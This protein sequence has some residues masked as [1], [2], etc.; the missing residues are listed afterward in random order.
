MAALTVSPDL[1]SPDAIPS[2]AIPTDAMPPD[3]IQPDAVVAPLAE[4]PV[5]ARYAPTVRLHYSE[6]YYPT[7]VGFFIDH[8][9]LRFSLQDAG[10]IPIADL[11]HVEPRKLGYRSF[12]DTYWWLNWRAWDKTRPYE[13]GRDPGLNERD[14]FFS[15]R[16][17]RPASSAGCA[18]RGE[19]S[20]ARRSSGA[21]QP[22]DSSSA[23]IRR[24]PAERQ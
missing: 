22:S 24:E 14:G 6:R 11:G 8:S 4:I 5:W 10:D 13:S 16:A 17:M 9:E 21:S 7:R 20:P 1:M 12:N 19:R 2:D 3:T 23:V 15:S 18:S